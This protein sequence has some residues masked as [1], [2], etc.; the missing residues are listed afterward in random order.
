MDPLRM[1]ITKTNPRDEEV[2]KKKRTRKR[3]KIVSDSEE[4]EEEDQVIRKRERSRKRGRRGRKMKIRKMIRMSSAMMSQDPKRRER[5]L[6]R[7]RVPKMNKKVPPRP[8]ERT[9]ERSSATKRSLKRPKRQ[10]AVLER[11]RRQRMEERQKVY[12]ATFEI[13]EGEELPL[14][15]DE[16]TKD[17]YHHRQRR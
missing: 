2:M 15:F 11:E 13:K 14:D 3:K 8:R 9:S 5:G 4:D 6:R 17:M 16:E 1:G 10:A 12:N 7:T